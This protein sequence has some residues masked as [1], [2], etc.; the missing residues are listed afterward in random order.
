ML[1][2]QVFSETSTK[3]DPGKKLDIVNTAKISNKE[4]EAKISKQFNINKEWKKVNSTSAFETWIKDKDYQIVNG[5][6][7]WNKAIFKI[8][9]AKNYDKVKSDKNTIVIYPTFTDSAYS[10]PG[11]YTYYRGECDEKCLTIKIQNNFVPQ[12]N[13]NAVQVL[14][15]LGY[16]FVT[17]VDVDKN[18]TI[19]GKYKKVIILHNEYVT[20]KEFDAIT[21]HPNV[22]YL[23]PNALHAEV[24]TDYTKNIITLIRGHNYPTKEIRNGFDWKLDNSQLEY[25]TEC[26]K[27]QFYKINNGWMLNCYP[28]NIIHK[29]MRFLETIK[30]L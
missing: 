10:E 28:E 4:F 27:M 14:K 16:S 21:S 11:F 8:D 7:I 3:T 29:S 9:P 2:Q 26:K 20:K 5:K 25:D 1:A 24:K 30:K 17:D 13:P 18:P 6:K 22:I 23:Y 12:A 19:L 15:L